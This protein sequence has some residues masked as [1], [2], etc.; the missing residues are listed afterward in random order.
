M[1]NLLHHHFYQTVSFVRA[2]RT[3]TFLVAAFLILFPVFWIQRVYREKI[4]P[5]IYIDTIDVSGKTIAEAQQMILQS[6]HGETEAVI[7][8]EVEDK[9][10]S[11]SAAQLGLERETQ[12]TLQRAFQEGHDHFFWTGM[13]RGLKLKPA[14]YLSTQAQ[15]NPEQTSTFI[16]TLKKEVDNPGQ[17]PAAVLTLTGSPASLKIQPGKPGHY[18]DD[19][20][21][22]KEIAR[23]WAGQNLTLPAIVASTAA[24]LTEPQIKEAQERAQKYVGKQIILTADHVKIFLNDQQLISLLTFPE[25][26]SEA[27][28]QT[29]INDWTKQVDRPVQEP[30]FEYDEKTSEVKKFTPPHKGLRLNQANAKQKVIDALHEFSHAEQKEKTIEIQLPVE[31][32]EPNKKL[33]HLNSLGINE[34]IGFGESQYEHS[35]PTRIH[36]VALTAQN[37][38]NTLVKPGQEFSFN[39]ELG[40]VSRETGFKPAYVIK[41][42]KTVL[43]DGGGVCQVSSTLFRAL[44]NA[45][46]P[47]TKRR[48]HSYRVSYYELNSKPGFDATVYSG[49]VDLRFINDTGHPLLIH[50]KTDSEKLYMYVEI[51]GTSDGRTTEIKD[52]KMWGFQSAPA[53]LYVEDPTIPRGSIKQ[54]D[55]AASGIKASF[56]NVVKDKDGKIIQENE[57]SSSYTPWRAIYLKGV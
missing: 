13:L 56:T 50:T 15:F 57:Y 54:I 2:Y 49:D 31:E 11:T 29:L 32:T 35:I 6:H 28:I 16:S 34:V 20:A 36:N 52:Y 4:Y 8:L 48:P 38:N 40:D 1:L 46:L 19:Q 24:T 53:P 41:E 26:F 44:L 55:F 7:T 21:T 5:N 17:E 45:G 9:H 18:I 12:T 47:I 3:F 14:V 23:K 33:S 37:I 39:N 22:Q 10:V 25:G 27:K 43:G 42:G 51:Y 30:E